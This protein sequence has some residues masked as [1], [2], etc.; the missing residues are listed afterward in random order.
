MR[1]PLPLA[2]ATAAALLLTACGD[3]EP[4]A[5]P[6]PDTRGADFP[7]TVGDVTLEEQ[8]T[9]IVSLSPAVTEMLFAL[10]AGEQVVA[11]DE[12]SN[13]PPEAPVTD[14]S[15]FTVNPEAVASYEPDL[16]VIS[17]YADEVVPQLG[18][19]D[20]PVHVAP[21]NPTTIDDVYGQITDLGA[22]TGHR[23]EAADLVERM[24][25]DLAKL[26]DDAPEREVPLTYY[27]E[28]DDTYWTYTSASVIGSLLSTVG[29]ENIAQEESEV[30]VQLTAEAIVAANPDVILLG[31]TAYG[32]DATSV[33][34]RP[35]W[36]E[37]TA[38]R[39]GQIVELD[40]DIASRWGPRLVD[41]VA[42]VVE[43]VSQVP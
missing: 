17:A 16:V 43:A 4:S 31:N 29:M 25:Q 11:V 3:N 28:I 26:A 39:E 23:D 42:A 33:A 36:S 6:T 20:I 30:S 27:F 41:L 38:V 15:G 2:L 37:I 9:R 10:G 24:R 13:Y 22:L 34:E 40:S 14:L 18:A 19:L 5:D 7:V 12:L 1:R 35:G 8:P 21:D 32:V